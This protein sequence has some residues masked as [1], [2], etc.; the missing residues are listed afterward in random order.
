M[1]VLQPVRGTHDY[2]GETYL[3][4]D[5][6]HRLALELALRHNYTPL[7]TPIFEFSS[8][9][10]RSLG[11]SSDVVSKE[12]Y[13]FID[14]NGEELTLRPEGTAAAARALISLGLA[15]DLPQ[16]F[17]YCGPMFRYERPQKGRT[18]QFHQLALEIFGAESPQ[19]DAEVITLAA[20]F[21]KKLGI[22]DRTVLEL[23][24]LG[25]TLSRQQYRIALVDYL[26]QYQQGL[27]SDS[28][29]R[30]QT[31][32]LR[33]LD[34][35]SPQD[36]EIVKNAPLLNDFL[37]A[38]A[39][40]FF[41]QVC[42]L[43]T[44]AQIPFV[45]NPFIVRGLD[46]YCHTTF[47]FITTEL[48]AQGTV[49]AGGRY[50]GLVKMLGGPD[51]CGIGWAAGIERLEALTHIPLKPQQYA[52]IIPLTQAAEAE[53]WA[54]YTRLQQTNIACSL[55]YSGN[56]SKR[57]KRAHKKGVQSVFLVDPDQPLGSIVVRCLQTG[58]QQILTEQELIQQFGQ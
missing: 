49:L 5:F 37:T 48:G 12:M 34:S 14:R 39:R 7:S 45:I 22:F 24:T 35:K 54:L 19:A 9:F 52:V 27:S 32:P 18:R 57:L 21:L 6:I 53:S 4:H 56:A 47:E 58:M 51:V 40:E 15:H 13:S 8:V 43:L 1:T 44:A 46:Y 11:D 30:L 16:K 23:N 10:K 38:S 28:Q 26:N 33:I 20:V 25:D 55:D 31:N 2:Y 50:D 29:R 41:D 17:Y 42:T 36:Q 3:K